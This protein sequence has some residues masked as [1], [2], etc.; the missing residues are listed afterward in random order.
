MRVNGWGVVEARQRNCETRPVRVLVINAGITGSDLILTLSESILAVTS[1][2]AQPLTVPIGYATSL[3]SCTEQDATDGPEVLRLARVLRPSLSAL[4]R[5]GSNP[6]RHHDTCSKITD[7]Q[8]HSPCS[9]VRP[10][11]VGLGIISVVVVYHLAVSLS[12]SAG[13]VWARP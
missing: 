6:S 13:F 5:F 9:L 2:A 3:A 7:K 4:R 10:H 11:G 1:G 12:A 8:Q